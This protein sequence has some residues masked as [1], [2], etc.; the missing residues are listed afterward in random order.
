MYSITITKITSVCSFMRWS[1]L[2]VGRPL[3]WFGLKMPTLLLLVLTVITA[4]HTQKTAS[5]KVSGQLQEISNLS[6]NYQDTIKIIPGS[7]VD[8]II[9]QSD[10]EQQK[11]PSLKASAAQSAAS[12]NELQEPVLIVRSGQAQAKAETDSHWKSSSKFD[13]SSDKELSINYKVLSYSFLVFT[14]AVFV[15]SY[16]VRRYFDK[17]K[18]L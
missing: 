5:E 17:D 13:I 12:N 15:L 1:L 6:W 18:N 10:P 11:S 3:T 8:F 7:F 4:C 2:N 9:S 16:V 14:L